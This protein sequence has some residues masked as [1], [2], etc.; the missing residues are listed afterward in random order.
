MVLIYKGK[1]RVWMPPPKMMPYPRQEKRN[2]KPV[3]CSAPMHL[4]QLLLVQFPHSWY[5]SNHINIIIL[6]DC[7]RHYGSLFFLRPIKISVS[8]SPIVFHLPVQLVLSL[9]RPPVDQ[10]RAPLPFLGSP[11]SAPST[12]GTSGPADR[13]SASWTSRPTSPPPAATCRRNVAVYTLRRW[14]SDVRTSWCT[15]AAASA[16]SCRLLYSVEEASAGFDGSIEWIA[17]HCSSSTAY[18][19]HTGRGREQSKANGLSRRVCAIVFAN[20]TICGGDRRVCHVCCA[21]GAAG[22]VVSE[23][24]GGDGGD[25]GEEVLE[26]VSQN[27]RKELHE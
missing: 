2:K 11:S 6:H 4:L 3:K 8:L 26:S 12:N 19:V 15:R 24:E 18:Q 25:A 5:S 22:T 14:L 23:G 21:G 27:S 16:P 20:G 9:S 13:A 17:W 7:S 10:S 1:K